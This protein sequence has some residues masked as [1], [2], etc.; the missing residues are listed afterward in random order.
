VNQVGYGPYAASYTGSVSGLVGTY[1]VTY[2]ILYFGVSADLKAAAE[3]TVAGTARIGFAPVA[4]A[5]DTDD[6]I[7][8]YKISNTTTSGQAFLASLGTEW[9]ISRDA[10]LQIEGEYLRIF[11]EGTQYQFFYAGPDAGLRISVPDKLDSAQLSL[12]ARLIFRFE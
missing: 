5:E 1:K 8:R 3:D 2:N 4:L 7:L 10:L 6:H 9:K 11:T 12:A